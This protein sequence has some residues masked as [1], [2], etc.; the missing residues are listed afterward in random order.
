MKKRNP[1]LVLLFSLITCGIYELY[2]YVVTTNEIEYEL[3]NSDGHCKSGGMAL[4]F[5]II[6]C[7]IYMFYWWFSQGRRV[8]Q[9]QRERNLPVGDNSILYLV[10]CFVGIGAIINTVVLQSSL[11]KIADTPATPA[12]PTEA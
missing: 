6:T 5:S 1:V 3:K 4:L 2:W 11:N 12:A 8:A 10:L 9:L 7:G